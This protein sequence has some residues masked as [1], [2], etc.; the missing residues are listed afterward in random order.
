MAVNSSSGNCDQC[1]VPV[2]MTQEE[3]DTLLHPGVL[4]EFVLQ[5]I[6]KM[7]AKSFND[8]INRLQNVQLTLQG[9]KVRVFDS[10]LY[11][12]IVASTCQCAFIFLI[13]VQNCFNQLTILW[14][15]CLTIDNLC[16]LDGLFL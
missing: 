5:A 7:K 3:P 1:Q 4:V 8:L 2:S 12:S 9:V 13:F 6:I 16:T 10:E 14:L 11:R 15:C